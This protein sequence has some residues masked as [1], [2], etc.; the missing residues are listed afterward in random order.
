MHRSFLAAL[1]FAAPVSAAD[2][3]VAKPIASL[4]AVEREG[5]NNDTIGL[6]WTALVG[7]GAP[8]LIPSLEA[9]DDD[10]PIAANWLLTAAGAVAEAETKAGRKLPHDKIESFVKNVKGAASARVLAYG[11]LPAADKDRL[12]P[13]FLNDPSADLRGLAVA[14]ELTKAKSKE[15]LEKVLGFARDQDQVEA[16][17]KKLEA[18]HKVKLVL[19]EHFGFVTQWHIVGPFASVQGKAL[20]MKHKPEEGAKV[21]EKLKGKADADVEWK[22]VTTRDKYGIVDL[23]AEIGKLHDATAYAVAVIHSEKEVPIEVRAT[24]PNALQMFVNGKKLFEREEYHHGENMDYHVGKGS[25]KAG[26]NVLLVKVCQNNQKDPWAQAW[27]FSARICDSTG[28]PIP[29]VTQLVG[30]TKVKLGSVPA[31]EEKK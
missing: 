17:A 27:R 12:L 5:K 4:K 13:S 6:A 24:T 31:S 21:G 10:K 28:A 3:A 7:Q 22:P 14:A 16:I 2:D 29:G 30:E 25:L 11:L 1:L 9:V 26:S 20:T 23:N 8:A 19:S 18:D 15:E